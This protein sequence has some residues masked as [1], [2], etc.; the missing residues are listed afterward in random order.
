MKCGSAG[1]PI[2][3]RSRYK[4]RIDAPIFMRREEFPVGNIDAAWTR[5][6]AGDKIPPRIDNR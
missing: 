4:K 5:Q 6:H 1:E 3:Y 2:G